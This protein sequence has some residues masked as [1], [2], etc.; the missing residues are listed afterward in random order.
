MSVKNYVRCDNCDKKIYFGDEVYQHSGRC[1]I[2][3]SA[4]CYADSYAE[5]HFLFGELA[6]ECCCTIYEEKDGAD[7]D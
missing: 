7:N 1:G 5:T 3:C 6:D 2:Y 4:Q